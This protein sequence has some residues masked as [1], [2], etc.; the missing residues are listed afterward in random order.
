M[1]SIRLKLATS[2]N[3]HWRHRIVRR[4][5]QVFLA[6]QDHASHPA[7][8]L[9]PQRN[10][11]ASRKAL[12]AM[13]FKP[14]LQRRHHRFGSSR[15]RRPERRVVLLVGFEQSSSQGQACDRIGTRRGCMLITSK[16]FGGCSDIVCLQAC[17]PMDF[18]T[19][20]HFFR[21]QACRPMECIPSTIRISTVQRFSRTLRHAVKT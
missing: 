19:T 10:S 21:P 12:D 13:G 1:K 16:R 8:P 20:S 9:I 7:W 17:R 14:R 11:W 4:H 5:H 2:E 15:P 3:D 6:L 18:V